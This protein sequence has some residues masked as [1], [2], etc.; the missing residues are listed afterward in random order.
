MLVAS[1]SRT[2]TPAL[3]LSSHAQTVDNAQQVQSTTNKTTSVNQSA[4]TRQLNAAV[5]S[6]AW[7]KSHSV[8][9]VIIPVGSSNIFD[10][11]ER[12]KAHIRHDAY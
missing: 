10:P 9:V 7:N 6:G 2:D 1:S 8:P 12:P 11:F 4:A 5:S 3:V